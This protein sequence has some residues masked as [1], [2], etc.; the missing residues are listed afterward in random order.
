M[1]VER[2]GH[3]VT[4]HKGENGFGKS[5]ETIEIKIIYT[6]VTQLELNRLKAEIDKIGAKA[7]VS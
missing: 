2:L 3:G 4:T 7:F 6:V 1:I 5:G